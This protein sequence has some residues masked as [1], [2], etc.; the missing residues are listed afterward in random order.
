M[1]YNRKTKVS[2]E[3]KESLFLKILYSNVVG[4]LILKIFTLKWFTSIGELYMN[5]KLSKLKIKKLIKKNKINMDEYE[6]ENYK[7][8]DEFFTRRIKSNKRKFN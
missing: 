4:R 2:Y 6:K 8:F 7:N 5:S 3:E 1:V